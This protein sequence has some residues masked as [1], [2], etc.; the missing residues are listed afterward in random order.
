VSATWWLETSDGLRRRIDPGGITLG[1][2]PRSD[3]VLSSASASRVHAIAHLAPKG[4]RLVQL[5]RGQT[6]VN[7]ELVERERD[8]A[9]GDTLEVPGLTLTIV[10]AKDSAESAGTGAAWV[11]ER[12]GGG[13]F[14]IS[15][16]PFMIGGSARDDLLVEGWAD[17]AI[18]LRVV[19]GALQVRASVSVEI[20]GA[21]LAPGASRPLA[22]GSSLALGGE[23][24]TLIAGG[25]L[26]EGSTV[27]EGTERASGARV[28]LEFLPRGG[29]LVVQSGDV[30]RAV[31]LPDRRCD[32]V[33]VLLAP[34]A[35]ARAGDLIGD[36]VVIARVWG[37]E[38]RDRTDINVLI[39][40]LRKDLA[41]GGLDI[42]LIE[43]AEGGGATR[44]VLEP[45][46]SVDLGS[47]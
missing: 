9:H 11:V 34:P 5:G 12:A 16:S 29:R 37:K 1:R 25:I 35:P 23:R 2:A 10:C 4:P 13:L 32:L 15:R 40:R 17:H 20:D 3:L 28:G 33:A 21:V 46:T 19:G 22:R 26:G 39:H 7:G 43:R 27:R 24:F 45:G 41:R 47:R 38:P 30:D 18:E 44:F 31:Y 14:G 8:L 6:R 36:E 42:G